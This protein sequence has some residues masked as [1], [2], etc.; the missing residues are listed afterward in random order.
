[1]FQLKQLDSGEIFLIGRLDAAQAEKAKPAFMALQTSAFV[2][3]SELEYIS[4]AGLGLL[5]MAQKRLN[6][7]GHALKLKNLRRHIHEIF[8]FA[9]F[10]QVFEIET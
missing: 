7:N 9:G 5:L 2:D 1:M 6:G 8:V 3:F 4:S 10:D